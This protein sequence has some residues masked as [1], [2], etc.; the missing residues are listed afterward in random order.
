[1]ATVGV[2]F[3]G[4]SCE[5]NISIITGVQALKCLDKIHKVI[6]IYIDN[7]GVWW[8]GKNFDDINVYKNK[9][10]KGKK[11]HL[12]PCSNSLYSEKGTVAKLDVVIL[13]NHGLNGEDGS[14]QGLL[15]MS[16]IPYTG[17]N[18]RASAIGM[19]KIAMKQIFSFAKLPMTRFLGFSKEEYTTNLYEL[20]NRIKANLEFPIIVKPS[21]LGSSIGISIAHNWQEL[22]E[23]VRV[24]LE[25][26]T[27]V[28]IEQA[29]QDF[30]EVNC[31]VLGRGESLIVSEVEQPIGWKEFLTFYDKYEKDSKVK[32]GEGRYM[33]AHIEPEKRKQ[34][35]EYAKAAF[36][37]LDA[38]GV[39]RVDFLIDNKSG[40]ILVNEINTIPGSLSNYL[41]SFD[42][43]NFTELLEKMMS[44]A[45][46]EHHDMQKLKYSYKSKLIGKGK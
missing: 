38:G 17:S 16:G 27:R 21:N 41:F 45:I 31:A 33:P 19:D 3:G 42:G 30:T 2:I 39:A 34:V 26:D 32:G 10:W 11:V 24:A 40:E 22:F 7:S 46:E 23:S 12:R 20:V 37:A 43:L 44:I 29:L 28:V 35:Q 5:H 1:M 13:A 14:L 8:T 36:R 18:V 9:S 15:Q 25:W 4:K 6:P